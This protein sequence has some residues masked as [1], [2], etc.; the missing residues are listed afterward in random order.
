MRITGDLTI[1]L[2]NMFLN[3]KGSFIPFGVLTIKTGFQQWV[4]GD[5]KIGP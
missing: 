2:Y 1:K 5:I 4:R 3:E